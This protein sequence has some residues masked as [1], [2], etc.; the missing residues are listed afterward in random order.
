MIRYEESIMQE[1][2]GDTPRE[3]YDNLMLLKTVPVKVVYND[4]IKQIVKDAQLEI[5]DKVLDEAFEI[6]DKFYIRTCDIF[7]LRKEL[8]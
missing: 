7:K 6:K 5:L 1:L 2:K 3:K 4:V 8:K